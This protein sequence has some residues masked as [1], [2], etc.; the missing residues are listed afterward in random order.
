MFDTS[1]NAA[2]CLAM[3]LAVAIVIAL[4]IFIGLNGMPGNDLQ[5]KIPAAVG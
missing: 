4:I 1:N 3:A 2:G 5:E